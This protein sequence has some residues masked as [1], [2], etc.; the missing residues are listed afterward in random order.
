MAQ[1]ISVVELGD[2]I[3]AGYCGRLLAG[4]GADVVKAEPA[5]GS[6]LRAAQPLLAGGESALFEYL[7]MYKRSLVLP[8]V[9]QGDDVLDRL[10]ARAD[11]VIDEPALDSGIGVAAIAA[12]A[13]RFRE[14]NPGVSRPSA[15]L[16]A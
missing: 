16:S 14:L 12:R 2:G 9:A 5:D 11:V 10:V 7:A 1:G 6:R 15:A 8:S 4:A 13:E 3:A